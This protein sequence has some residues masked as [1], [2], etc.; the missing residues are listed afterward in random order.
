[1]NWTEPERLIAYFWDAMMMY[2]PWRGRLNNGMWEKLIPP[3]SS[4]RLFL[5]SLDAAK[6]GEGP[7]RAKY[8]SLLSA[9]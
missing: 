4:L 6:V 1:M 2:V 8:S 3:C 9:E 5:T 7:D